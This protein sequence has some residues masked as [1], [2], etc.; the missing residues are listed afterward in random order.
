V[1]KTDNGAVFKN[2]QCL[3]MAKYMFSIVLLLVLYKK[4]TLSGEL[5][6]K[7]KIVA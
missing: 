1:E 7:N 6:V 5:C 4:S 3:H 2:Y